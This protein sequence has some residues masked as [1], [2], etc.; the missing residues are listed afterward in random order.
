MTKEQYV[1]VVMITEETQMH[2][3]E[4]CVEVFSNLDKATV[5]IE[6]EIDRLVSE[7]G[8][9]REK[10]A[11][12]W[13]ERRPSSNGFCRSREGDKAI[14]QTRANAARHLIGNRQMPSDVSYAR[15]CSTISI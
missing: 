1:A 6:G 14:L 10:L 7:Y 11:R 5:W 13:H 4:E 15:W 8:L 12:A 2:A 9:D 3:F